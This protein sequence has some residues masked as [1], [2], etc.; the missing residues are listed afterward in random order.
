MVNLYID[1]ISV[2]VIKNSTVL[3]ACDNLGIDIPRFC[4]HE[5][6]LIAGN[7]RMCLVEIEKSPKPVASCALPVSEGMRVFTNTPLVKKAQEGV[8]EFLLLN[9]PL[10]CPICDQGGECDLQDQVMFFGSDSSRFYEYKRAVEDKDC[11]PLV[12]TIM[13]RCIHCT[14][15]I[16]FSSEIAGV[17]DLGALGRGINT[18]IG[19]YIEKVLKSELSG[20][21]IDLCPVGSFTSKKG[22]VWFFTSKKGSVRSFTSEKG[23]DPFIDEIFADD[24]YST[25][26]VKLARAKIDADFEWDIYFQYRANLKDPNVLID[27]DEV[28]KRKLLFRSMKHLEL[29]IAVNAFYHFRKACVKKSESHADSNLVKPT[30]LVKVE[31]LVKPTKLV[32]LANLVKIEELKLIVLKLNSACAE[33]N[34]ANKRLEDAVAKSSD[35]RTEFNLKLKDPDRSRDAELKL[36]IFNLNLAVAEVDLANERLED[37]VVKFSDL[38]TELKLKLEDP[39]S[40]G[41]ADLRLPKLRLSDAELADPELKLPKLTLSAVVLDAALKFYDAQ[42]KLASSGLT[43]AELADAKLKLSDAYSKF[44]DARLEDAKLKVVDAKSNVVDAKLKVADLQSKVADAQSKLADAGPDEKF[45]AAAVLEDAKSE[46]EYAKV[47]LE[48][49]DA[50]LACAESKFRYLAELPDEG[51]FGSVGALTSKPYAFK[52]RSWELKFTNSIDISDSC[53]S[54]IVINS[55]G[56]E[57]LR[58]LPRLNENINEEWIS[59]KTRFFYDA[60][61]VQRLGIPLFLNFKIKQFKELSWEKSFNIFLVN[62]Y[63]SVY[64]LDNKLNIIFGNET[65]LETILTV[66]HLFN[67]L[68]CFSLYSTEFFCNNSLDL[69]YKLDGQMKNINEHDLCIIVNCD[70]RLETSMLNLHLRKAVLQGSLNVGYFGPSIDLTFEKKHLGFDKKTFFDLLKGKHI[71]CKE[72]KKAKNPLFLISS[73]AFFNKELLC[74]NQIIRN[75]L[76]FSKNNINILNIHA[77][78]LNLREIGIKSLKNVLIK[79]QNF[80]FN[81]YIN[82][83][84]N[85]QQIKKLFKSKFSVYCG[86][87]GVKEINNIDLILPGK[88]FTE[89]KSSFINLEGLLQNTNRSSAGL[90]N[91]REDWKIFNAFT[92]YLN[93]NVNYNN[94]LK[95]NFDDF[96][97][98]RDFFKKEYKFLEKTGIYHKALFFNIYIKNFNFNLSFFYKSKIVNFYKTNILSFF[99]TIMTDCSNNVRK[100]NLKKC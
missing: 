36:I 75:H 9:H 31:E 16:R 69:I 50:E 90:I 81:L 14:R 35:A 25:P 18:Q 41:G 23:Y 2:S 39:V 64:N 83:C 56:T 73:N 57:V 87:H 93:F 85:N 28:F 19:T 53:G 43:G 68:N 62:I 89:K 24:P 13:T 67:K 94:L 6:L 96:F 12:K 51:P 46:L 61:V 70:T 15:C 97:S 17:P 10:D 80:F 65:D 58:I 29:T 91:S 30:K 37:A 34:L 74:L 99:S 60:L 3:Q 76:N 63:K 84:L 22:S 78:S 11:G 5:R 20:N 48:I 40:D 54:N 92:E 1:N 52:G 79:K 45:H 32:T 55:K 98:L 8:L 7:C 42:S 88:V 95:I 26:L 33:V 66:K 21:I 47:E 44:V 100:F 72:L 71:F 86:S 49:A 38:R 82:S 27:T 77:S 4:F 59:D